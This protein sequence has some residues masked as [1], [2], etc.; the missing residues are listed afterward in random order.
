V[1]RL[2][3]S[4]VLGLFAPVVAFMG[5]EVVE[6]PGQN[7]IRER[8]VGGLAVALYLAI[9]QFLVTPRG[10]RKLGANWPTMVALGAPL[11]ALFF[12]AQAK[13]LWERGYL[14][15]PIVISGWLGILAGAVVAARVTL[16]TVS[17]AFCR[18]WLLTCAALL[19]AVALVVAAGVV[20]LTKANTFPQATP[21]NAVPVFWGIVVLNLLV[22][23]SL[24]FIAVRAGDGRRLSPIVLGF[25]AFLAFVPACLLAVAGFASLGHGPSMRIASILL[26]LCSAA[27]F[28]VT[29]LVS[30]TALLLASEERT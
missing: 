17:L 13:D 16:P 12:V 21:E 28:L 1:G 26:L 30:T 6:V 27:E 15:G 3:L 9:C 20:P 4:I 29:G 7:P 8:V 22:A 19:V 5:A 25:L 11:L 14:Y 24:A 23:A 10:S 18:R 2:L